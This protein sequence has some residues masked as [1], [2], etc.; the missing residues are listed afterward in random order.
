MTRRAAAAVGAMLL[1]LACGANRSAEP[2]S[3]PSTGADT[4]EGKV[5]QVGSTPFA[6]TVVEGDSASA[7]VEGEL[8]AEL[9]RLVGARV[10]VTG[11]RAEGEGPGPSLL[12]ESYEILSV[13]GDEPLVGV[14]RHE[15]GVGYRL[16]TEE[17]GTV[18]LRGVPTELGA[19]EG[20]KVWVVTGSDGGVQ[21]YGILRDP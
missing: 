6:R 9:S 7:A 12:V 3:E 1:V 19:A 21:R 2:G 13:D 10:R 15:A 18:P 11:E 4:L 5:R 14:L 8:A 20:G 17:G 16:E